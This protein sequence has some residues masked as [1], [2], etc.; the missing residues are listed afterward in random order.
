MLNDPIAEIQRI[1]RRLTALKSSSE[2]LYDAVRKL[3]RGVAQALKDSNEKKALAVH[4]VN[5]LR[6]EI[7]RRVLDDEEVDAGVIERIQRTIE[8]R[9]PSAFPGV[10]YPDDFARRLGTANIKSNAFKNWQDH[11]RVCYPFFYGGR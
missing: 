6:Y 11:F 10:G 7:L 8:N 3:D 4:P 9:D 2:D 1:G 5:L